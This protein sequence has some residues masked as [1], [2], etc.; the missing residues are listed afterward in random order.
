MFCGAVC[1]IRFSM[2]E[3]HNPVEPSSPEDGDG[4][5]SERE[6][7]LKAGQ[8]HEGQRLDMFLAACLGVTRSSAKRL[9]TGGNVRLEGDRRAK[10]GFRVQPGMTLQVDLPPALPLEPEAEPV[11]FE[12]VYEDDRILV[13][14]KPAGI[15]VHPAPGNWTGTLVHGLL[16]R[17]P[18]LRDSGADPRRP[19]IVHRLDGPTSGLLVVARDQKALHHLQDQFRRREVTKIYIVLVQGG[20]KDGEGIIEAPIGRSPANRVRMAVLEDGRQAVTMYRRLWVRKGFSLLECNIP[21][22]RTH[23]IRV[24]LS[25]IGHPVAGDRLYGA[26]EDPGLPEGRI[27][28]HSQKLSFVH[29][30]TGCRLAFTSFLPA[31]LTGRLRKILSTDRD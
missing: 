12:V 13:I 19:G 8:E 25:A 11:P 28:L 26:A 24:H 16:H 1:L 29:P 5:F 20:V 15:L 2:T 7:T 9:V 31:E 4:V 6:V 3:K 22:G 21:T 18:S 10:A 27:F 23:Q 14:D 17:Y 30:E